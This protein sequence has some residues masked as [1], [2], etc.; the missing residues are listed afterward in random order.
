MMRTGF[1]LGGAGSAILRSD[2]ELMIRLDETLSVSPQVILEE[3]LFGWKEI[4][5]EVVRDR[6]GTAMTVC[7]MENVDPVR[8]SYR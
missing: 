8:Y 1:A 7:N 2:H 4:E 6:H 3:C 5:Y